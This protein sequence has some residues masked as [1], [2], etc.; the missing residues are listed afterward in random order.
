MWELSS[1]ASHVKFLLENRHLVPWVT[2]Q[3]V[4]S[5]LTVEEI[6]NAGK[7]SEP[8]TERGSTDT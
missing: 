3:W 5:G 4:K 6:E 1:L 7:P 2:G 8:E